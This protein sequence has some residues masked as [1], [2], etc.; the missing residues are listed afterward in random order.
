MPRLEISAVALALLTTS[1]SAVQ[2][3]ATPSPS[4]VEKLEAVVDCLDERF[5]DRVGP[6][7]AV[8]FL[9]GKSPAFIAADD[10]C[11]NLDPDKCVKRTPM[12]PGRSWFTG[13]RARGYV[14][15]TDGR[16]FGWTRSGDIATGPIPAI[17]PREWMGSWSAGGAQFD[18]APGG[19]GKTLHVT[20][21]TEWRAGP[22][23]PPHLG[24]LDYDGALVAN[25][26][27]IGEVRCLDLDY[28][29]SHDECARCVAR[30]MYIG[31]RI[32]VRD[33]R[34]CGGMNVNFNGVYDRREKDF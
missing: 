13:A 6:F 1:A 17:S 32:L 15:V 24:D 10:A 29:D 23:S 16:Q 8:R 20:G 28:Q 34:F 26:L 18:I 25:E 12:D 7:H 2:N 19:D 27:R 33:N 11:L 22:D 31:G 4:P 21:T 30:L 14:C 5:A 9:S 3:A